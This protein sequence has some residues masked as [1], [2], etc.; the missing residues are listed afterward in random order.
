MIIS[1]G[2]L[3]RSRLVLL[4]SSRSETS[5]CNYELLPQ[6]AP[7]YRHVE[8][9][10]DVIDLTDSHNKPSEVSADRFHVHVHYSD[11]KPWN[12]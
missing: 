9:G 3:F 11:L 5:V 6:F 1:T 4:K 12:N 2:C 7:S 8:N 10:R